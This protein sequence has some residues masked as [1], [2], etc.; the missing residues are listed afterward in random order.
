MLSNKDVCVNEL[1][2]GV[3][4]VFALWDMIAVSHPCVVTVKP[5]LLTQCSMHFCAV[6]LNYS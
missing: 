6:C 3:F 5:G 1:S 2:D 4:I